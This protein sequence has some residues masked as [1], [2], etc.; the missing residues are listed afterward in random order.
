MYDGFLRK[1]WIFKFFFFGTKT[2]R[3]MFL[4]LSWLI[5]SS[6]LWFWK[7]DGCLQLISKSPLPLQNSEFGKVYGQFLVHH[8]NKNVQQMAISNF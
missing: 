2:S 6:I 1:P 4:M 7:A 3:P 5:D 8:C